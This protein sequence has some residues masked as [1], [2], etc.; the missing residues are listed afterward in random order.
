MD[1]PTS[2]KHG[3]SW[4]QARTTRGFLT[5]TDAAI[6]LASSWRKTIIRDK[7]SELGHEQ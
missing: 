2:V 5:T 3:D 7:V 4:Q 6:A 1:I